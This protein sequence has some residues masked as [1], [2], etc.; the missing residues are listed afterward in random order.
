MTNRR[1][2]TLLT[3]ILSAFA[4]LI[5][6]LELQTS[7]PS[8]SAAMTDR[9]TM[10]RDPLLAAQINT[11]TPNP[12][13]TPL[14]TNT[15]APP[16]V[17][18]SATLPSGDDFG[19]ITGPDHTVAPIEYRTPIPA[20]SP[21]F[22]PSPTSGPALRRD[23][24]GVQIHP[25][26]DNNDYSAMLNHA[27]TLGVTWIKF[28]F[29]WSLLESAPGSLTQDFYML[30]LYVQQAHIQGFKV[31]VSVAKAPGWS[32][33]PDAG[34]I[35]RED[36][37][38]RDP[39]MLASFLNQML[40]E[41]GVDVHGNPY[42]SAI[43]VWNEPN[44]QREWY[45][46]PIT[47]AEYMRY[48]APAY[49]VIRTYSPAITIITAAPAPTGDSA[50]S[51]NDRIWLQQLYNAG[52]AGYGGNIAVGIHPY[53]WANASDARCCAAAPRG[54]D[55]QPQFFFL[56]TVEDYR[57][58]MTA[59]GHSNALLWTTEFGWAT[60]DGLL[61]YQGHQP[62]DPAGQPFFSFIDRLQQADYTI[63]ALELAQARGYMGPMIIW[64]LN[65][66]TL[67]GAVD[68]SNPQTG[69]GLLDTQRQPRPVYHALQAVPKQ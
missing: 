41:I 35:M 49:N 33:N 44:L 29:N 16:T 5:A 14:P 63:L 27:R 56:D 45:A 10:P 67:P 1:V 43:E 15:V 36:G 32:R 23:L 30:R 3:L 42:I 51:T 40:N 47:G 9:A 48:F 39:A 65:F 64:N 24:I 68:T 50:A 22:G 37:P 55:D 62:P 18:A 57:Q 26:I 60:F 21:T 2:F 31:L 54:W 38:P 53:G 7:T 46:H 59:N 12:A 17:T 4:L 25:H 69:Y 13:L 52:L 66:A 34:G 20:A 6:A 61:T 8:R 58:I 28:Q 11:N 19:P